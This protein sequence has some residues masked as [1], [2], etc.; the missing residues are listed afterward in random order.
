VSVG[1]WV[2]GRAGMGCGV[3]G[4]DEDG[5]CVRPRVCVCGGGG[6]GGA[7]CSVFEPNCCVVREGMRV[8]ASPRVAYFVR[9]RE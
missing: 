4:M 8:H 9:A 3:V 1:E 7:R 6:G 2:G 5:R